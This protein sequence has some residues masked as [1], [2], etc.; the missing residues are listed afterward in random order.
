MGFFEQIV[1]ELIPDKA[2][3]YLSRLL[4]SSDDS[5]VYS[6]FTTEIGNDICACLNTVGGEVLVRKNGW[7]DNAAIES[8][9]DEKLNELYSGFNLNPSK[10]V[11]LM[12]P[13]KAG[14]DYVIITITASNDG[15]IYT[16]NGK[17]YYRENN[18]VKT[19]DDVSEIIKNRK[20]LKG[21]PLLEKYEPS[22]DDKNKDFSKLS[23]DNNVKY[24]RIGIPPQ[25]RATFYKYFTLDI[26]L[27]ILRKEESPKG[28]KIDGMRNPPQTLQFVEPLAWEDQYERR[29][30]LANY[31][32]VNKEQGNTPQLLAT[33]FTHRR[34]SE[35]AWQ[36]YNRG[37][38]GLGKRCVQFCF[39]QVAL[40]MELVKNLKDCTIVEG[41][42]QYL[43]NSM[44]NTLHLSTKE[45]GSENETYDQY[46]SDFSLDNFINLLL[47]KRTAFEHEQE[48]RI[49]II[50]EKSGRRSKK[51]D[52]AQQRLI[53]L[54]WL[55]MLE[56]IKVD[57][58]CSDIEIN[59]LQDEINR[60][61][62][63]SKNTK[64]K[65]KELFKK[66]TVSRYDVNS[67]IEKDESLPIGETNKQYEKRLLKLQSKK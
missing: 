6:S 50:D 31:K 66:L 40:R 21:Q 15:E 60:L 5:N 67:D 42:V 12:F 53:S 35:P 1:K 11:S 59:L 52:K 65:K 49:F 27:S 23:I 36:I 45:D 51:Q 2:K 25:N 17:A 64:T 14:M 24:L 34:D 56:G 22:N 46:F 13:E 54:D 47:L 33:C 62:E 18:K 39:N 38:E 10:W 58:E 63:D 19:S 44:I 3:K 8:F 30:Y 61:I 20:A 57:P 29:F 16:Y 37:K 55:S 7:D 41:V 9:F 4:E 32:K 26:A 48:V 43:S 28:K